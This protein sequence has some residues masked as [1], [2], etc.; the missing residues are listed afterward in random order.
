VTVIRL[1]GAVA[2]LMLGA[3]ACGATTSEPQRAVPP[4]SGRP[5]ALRV[6]EAPTPKLAVPNYRTRG[7]YPQVAGGRTSLAAVNA[8]LTDVVRSEQRRYARIARQNQENFPPPPQSGPGLF[9]TNFRARSSVISASSVVVSTLI[10]LTRLLP[11][12]N[13]GDTWLSATIRVPSGTAVS[14]GDLF[15]VRSRGLRA[16]AAAVRGQ[17]IASNSCVKQSIDDLPMLA[18]GFAPTRSNYQYFALTARGMVIGLTQAQVSFPPCN[19]VRTTV[20]YSKLRANLSPLAK[21]LI[22]GVRP[23]RSG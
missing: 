10:P 19:R 6:T 3:T 23:P 9:A 12:G 15:A 18:R 5:V 14:V 7:T 21:K 1:S 8:A 22:A 4:A 20:P 16:L 17:V 2:A 13:D 11:S